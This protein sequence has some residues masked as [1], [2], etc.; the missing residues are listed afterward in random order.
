M[1]NSSGGITPLLGRVL[2]SLIFIVA[3]AQKIPAFSMMKGY[4]AMAHLPFPSLALAIAIA[5]E[6][7]G[8][9]AIL[10]G[11]WTRFT[12]WVVF[13]YLIPTTLC[14]HLLPALH[15]TD[16]MNNIMNVEKNLAIM[17]GLLLLAAHG[18]GRYSCDG[19]GEPKA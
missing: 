10:A 2:M 16:Q 8:G 19:A 6:L 9:L 15:G 12:A 7:V 13:L 18:A 3:G 1:A 14:F 17:G 5:I 11:L 4:V